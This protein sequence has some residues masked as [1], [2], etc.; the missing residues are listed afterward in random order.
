MS[1][2]T[3]NKWHGSQVQILTGF[4]SSSSSSAVTNI[5]KANPAVVT[6]S[7]H[8]LEIGDVVTITGVVGMTEV[9]DGIFIVNVLTPNTFEL[10]GV[11]ST[12]Y[13]AYV[14][15]GSIAAGEF[16]NWCDLTNYNRQGGTSPE[17]HTETICSDAQEYVLG[18]RDPGTTQMDY[19]FDHMMS[20]VQVALDAFYTSGETT[21]VRMVL[22]NNRGNRVQ[23]GMVQ[24]MSEQA[25]NGTIWTGSATIRNTGNKF[26]YIPA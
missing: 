1:T 3:V 12:G 7:S 10:F 18:L 23:R 22:P 20:N 5:S 4:E 25:G 8:G 2:G 26:D 24:Q 17:V 11:D 21:A 15:G 9:N 19:N 6:S 13:G 16:S 14:S